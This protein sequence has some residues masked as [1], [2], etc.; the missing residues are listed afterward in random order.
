MQQP[1]EIVHATRE[2]LDI[3]VDIYNTTIASRKVTA[4]LEPVTVESRIKWFNEHNEH[5]RPLWVMKAEGE[6]IA[7][8]SLSDFHSRAAYDATAEISIYISPKSRSQGVGSLFLQKAL[9]QC[10]RLHI[11]NVVALVFGHND[12]SLALLKKFGFEQWGL[13]PGVAIL[14]GVE[15]DLV[16]MGIKV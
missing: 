9:E 12:P 7:W 8:L 6:I 15:R 5:R 3:I 13:L 1:Y 2:E 11:R 4:D 14:D 10:P 16:M